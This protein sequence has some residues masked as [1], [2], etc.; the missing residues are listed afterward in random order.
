M[1]PMSFT[2]ASTLNGRI[3]G[4]TVIREIHDC[5]YR[6]KY[7]LPDFLD[8]KSFISSLK[9]S[10]NLFKVINSKYYPSRQIYPGVYYGL[11]QFIPHQ[12]KIYLSSRHIFVHHCTF[13][14]SLHAKRMPLTQSFERTPKRPPSVRSSS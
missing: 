11:G 6:P 5:T 9:N 1:R 12:A 4:Q 7:F 14:A 10:Y 13:C 8:P 3:T 2:T